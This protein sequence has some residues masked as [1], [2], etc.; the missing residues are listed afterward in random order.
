MLGSGRGEQV[1]RE[2]EATTLSAAD[3]ELRVGVLQWRS[4]GARVPA[5]GGSSDGGT[6]EEGGGGGD[7]DVN[8]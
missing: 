3:G 4:E 5:A 2:E 8:G 1:Q 6:G 7:G